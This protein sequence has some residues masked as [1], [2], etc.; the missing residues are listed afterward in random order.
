MTRAAAALGLLLLCACSSAPAASTPPSPAATAAA[1]HFPVNATAAGGAGIKGTA[2]VV[3]V[4]DNAFDLS[5]DVSGLAPNS[6]HVSHIH[7]GTCGS[8]GAIAI[9]L[10][11][12]VADAA[13]HASVSNS[14]ASPYKGDGWYVNIHAGSDLTTPAN[15]T[16]IACADLKSSP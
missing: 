16:P 12:L 10:A 6:I 8:N 9:P 2:T 7:N 11:N 5:L 13:G 1:M 4:A 15:A 14:I 3:K